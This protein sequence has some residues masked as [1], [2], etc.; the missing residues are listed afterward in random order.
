MLSLAGVSTE[1]GVY[2]IIFVVYSG[3][4]SGL[5]NGTVLSETIQENCRI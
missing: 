2:I 3:G 4:E 1:V 5:G